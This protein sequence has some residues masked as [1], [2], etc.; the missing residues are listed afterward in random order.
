MYR[1]VLARE[2]IDRRNGGEGNSK[3]LKVDTLYSVYDKKVYTPHVSRQSTTSPHQI[4][5][6][7]NMIRDFYYR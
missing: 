7:E 1:L 2:Y 4:P 5:I 6:G 3:A